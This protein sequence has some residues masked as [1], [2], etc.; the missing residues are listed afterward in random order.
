MSA[1]PFVHVRGKRVLRRTRTNNE[2]GDALRQTTE[3]HEFSYW[4][5]DFTRASCLP[6]LF[7]SLS[8]L[9]SYL[10]TCRGPSLFCT[11]ESRGFLRVDRVI[12]FLPDCFVEPRNRRKETLKFNFVRIWSSKVGTRFCALDA[13]FL[14]SLHVFNFGIPSAPGERVKSPPCRNL[15]VTKWRLNRYLDRGN[16]LLKNDFF[17]NILC[18]KIIGS[19]RSAVKMARRSLLAPRY[20]TVSVNGDL[21]KKKWGL[22]CARVQVHVHATYDTHRVR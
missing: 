8:F 11:S 9:S 16:G 3:V 17:I 22:L 20:A 2:A 5:F 7:F 6:P 13:V 19:V 14:I 15:A 10:S 12:D 4:L 18:S 21:R 1:R